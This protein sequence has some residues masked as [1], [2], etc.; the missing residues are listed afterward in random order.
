VFSHS[1]AEPAAANI[2]AIS[3]A[4]RRHRIRTWDP[5]LK[6]SWRRCG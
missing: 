4:A 5:A 2:S 1:P 6:K 3:C